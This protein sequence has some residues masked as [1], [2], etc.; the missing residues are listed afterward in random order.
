VINC[1][2]N[3]VK[4]FLFDLIGWNEVFLLAAPVSSK[5]GRVIMETPPCIARVELWHSLPA[6]LSVQHE[7]ANRSTYPLFEE[8]GGYLRVEVS[9]K[10]GCAFDHPTTF[11][12]PTIHSS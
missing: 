12:K 2:G 3:G 1:D 4:V 5:V 9:L 7:L 6:H 10:G 8:P 11:L